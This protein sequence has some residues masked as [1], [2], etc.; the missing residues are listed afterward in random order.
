MTIGEKI[1]GLR[2]NSGMLQNELAKKLGVSVRTVQNYE[3]NIFPSNKEKVLYKIADVFTVS[4]ESLTDS[5]VLIIESIPGLYSLGSTYKKLERELRM[6]PYNLNYFYDLMGQAEIQL[7][8]KNWKKLFEIYEDSRFHCEFLIKEC[9][10]ILSEF[11]D[12]L[13]MLIHE[14]KDAESQ[15]R[16]CK[17]ILNYSKL[18]KYKEFIYERQVIYID[19][20]FL[21]KLSDNACESDLIRMFE[22][23]KNFSIEEA[24]LTEKYN[25]YREQHDKEFQERLNEQFQIIS[26][27]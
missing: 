23:L 9:T 1:K 2:L 5:D 17:Y 16:C 18:Q 13:E 12:C 14:T 19:S 20:M 15:N 7:K 8:N 11:E 25:I 27:E 22:K 4:I 10:K 6:M 26:K 21:C 24:E 3:N